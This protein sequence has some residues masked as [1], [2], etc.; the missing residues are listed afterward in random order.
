MF[1]ALTPSFI[2]SV[3]LNCHL[4][5]DGERKSLFTSLQWVTCPGPPC[6]EHT[7]TH[8]RTHAHGVA[9]R[10]TA[11][12]WCVRNC[13]FEDAFLLGCNA[14][15]KSVVILWWEWGV[16]V[17]SLILKVKSL[18]SFETSGDYTERHGVTSQNT[19]ISSNA[20][21]LEILKCL[22]ALPTLAV[23]RQASQQ[24]NAYVGPRPYRKP[25][26]NP[27]PQ[28]S[29]HYRQGFCDERFSSVAVTGQLTAGYCDL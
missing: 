17:N 5:G 10:I 20:Q 1:R 16:G 13:G 2:I 15:S 27:W 28:V 8:T 4:E 7:H 26:T 29:V 25:E 9:E 19:L 12:G 24:L 21:W 3:R 11:S 14:V 23:S 22:Y 18:R 6:A